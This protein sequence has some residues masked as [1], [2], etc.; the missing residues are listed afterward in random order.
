MPNIPQIPIHANSQSYTTQN[1][2]DFTTQ[3]RN[4]TFI[5][6]ESYTPYDPYSYDSTQNFGTNY[7]ELNHLQPPNIQPYHSYFDDEY[8]NE[9]NENNS[10]NEPILPPRNIAPQHSITH[11]DSTSNAPEITH[12]DISVNSAEISDLSALNNYAIGPV[13]A[14]ASAE[15]I[16]SDSDIDIKLEKHK[17]K[18][19]RPKRRKS[20]CKRSKSKKKKSK[21]K[22]KFCD[23]SSD[24]SVYEPLEKKRKINISK[25][26]LDNYVSETVSK[27]KALQ[28][29]NLFLDSGECVIDATGCWCYIDKC[30]K[31][32]TNK[33]HLK[34]HC[35]EQ[36]IGRGYKCIYNKCNSIFKQRVQGKEHVKNIH[37]GDNRQ[38]IC[39]LCGDDFTRWWGV[40]RH[41]E[42]NRCDIINNKKYKSTYSTVQIAKIIKDAQDGKS[43]NKCRVNKFHKC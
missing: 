10:S 7:Y 29:F 26:E 27:S 15:D 25:N 5:Q 13:A 32:Y 12:G 43:R 33:C 17:K 39:Y 3:I 11:T 42:L 41:L 24:E 35:D 19:R 31:S 9:Q 40:R 34:R 2:P 4:N 22:R 6:N 8:F 20:V 18:K 23:N 16:H 38:W 37:F 14:P 1:Q 30:N 28:E 36:H 21:R